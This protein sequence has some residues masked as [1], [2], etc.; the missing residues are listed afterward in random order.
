MTSTHHDQQ[1]TATGKNSLQDI[2][3][4]EAEPEIATGT[5][6]SK[7]MVCSQT[8]NSHTRFETVNLPEIPLYGPFGTAEAIDFKQF[9]V[10]VPSERDIEV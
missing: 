3:I 1:V 2:D 6:L 8:K 9:H 4:G 7:N 5:I 10:Q